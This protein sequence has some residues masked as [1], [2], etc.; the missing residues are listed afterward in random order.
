[1]AT[2]AYHPGAVEVITFWLTRLLNKATTAFLNSEE[3][4]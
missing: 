2:A 3:H 1:M 4:T